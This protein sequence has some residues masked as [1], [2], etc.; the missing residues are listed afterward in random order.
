MPK[1]TGV[2]ATPPAGKCLQQLCKPF[3]HKAAVRFGDTRVGVSGIGG[4]G[5]AQ[6]PLKRNCMTS[7]SL[8][9]RIAR[10]TR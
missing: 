8:R 10:M 5:P 4:A 7:S 6:Y 1:E 9:M 2:F 3:G